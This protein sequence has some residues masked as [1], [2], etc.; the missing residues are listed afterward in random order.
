MYHKGNSFSTFSSWFDRHETK[1]EGR[2]ISRE[3]FQ[4]FDLKKGF[5]KGDIL[6]IIGANP[7]KLEIGDVILFKDKNKEDYFK[8]YSKNYIGK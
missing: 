4:D 5:S 3:K 1:Y 8:N 2:D 6:F 7:E